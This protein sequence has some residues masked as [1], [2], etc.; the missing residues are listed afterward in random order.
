MLLLSCP[1]LESQFVDLEW[2]QYFN[3]PCKILV[4]MIWKL[5]FSSYM[6]EKKDKKLGL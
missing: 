6:L 4:Q 5:Q 3:Q 1:I 2:D